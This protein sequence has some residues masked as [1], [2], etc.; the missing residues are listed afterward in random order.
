MIDRSSTFNDLNYIFPFNLRQ[1]D[2]YEG[3]RK[4]VTRFYLRIAQKIGF[5]SV[6]FKRRGFARMS[7]RT[8]SHEER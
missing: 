5:G 1:C 7:A 4:Q 3:G 6:A 8:S 2:R